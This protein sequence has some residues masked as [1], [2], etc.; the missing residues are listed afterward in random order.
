MK[1]LCIVGKKRSGKDT[2][3][4]LISEEFDCKTIALA[5]KI[6][7]LLSGS[8]KS[9]GLKEST[10]V[11]LTL[12]DFYDLGGYDREQA[13]HMSN[14]E[15][16]E[17]FGHSLEML[18]REYPNLQ[19]VRTEIIRDIVAKNKKPWSIRNLMQTFG[20]DIVVNHCN[21]MI[22]ITIAMNAFIEASENDQYKYFIITDVRQGH[23]LTVLENLGATCLFLK[24]DIIESYDD[25]STERG[26]TP[27]PTD[28][29]IHN[30]GSLNDLK[31]NLIKELT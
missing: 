26:L 28:I 18:R 29:V 11:D 21:K 1:L 8:Y 4:E 15:A 12:D 10:F 3:T 24:R 31:D 25:H 17:L 20:T 9:I 6:K 22:W 19:T 27:K 2:A 14:E 23:E 7:K 30:N 5:D 13:L 16:V